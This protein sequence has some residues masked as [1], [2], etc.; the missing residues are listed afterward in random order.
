L[1]RQ[2]AKSAKKT[3]REEREKEFEFS[4]LPLGDLGA[5]AVQFFIQE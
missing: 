4:L 2:D 3:Q 1:N 5:L